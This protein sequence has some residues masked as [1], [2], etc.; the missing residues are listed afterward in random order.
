[1]VYFCYYLQYSVLFVLP[2]VTTYCINPR[3]LYGKPS[4][5]IFIHVFIIY[6]LSI[7]FFKPHFNSMSI[8]FSLRNFLLYL[9]WYMFTGRRFS[10]SR[11]SNFSL[12]GLI[13]E[14]YFT[15]KFLLIY[16]SR[17]YLIIFQFLMFLIR[18]Q[19]RE[20]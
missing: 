14:R 8:I 1:M 7:P 4:Y 3:K 20:D 11:L 6:G 12:F 18:T 9:L 10:H 2:I 16:F 5:F 17:Y 13:L 19:K 15:H